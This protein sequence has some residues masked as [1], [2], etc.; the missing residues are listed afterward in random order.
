[1]KAPATHRFVL[2]DLGLPSRLTIG[3]FLV[4]IGFGYCA[5]L[6]QLHFQHATPGKL[7]PDSED[8][9]NTYYGRM[10]MSQLERLLVVDEAKPFN[11]SGSMRQ[12]FTTKSAGWKGAINR[13]SKEK[14]ISL[15]AAE[16]ELRSERDG[17]RLAILDW[18]RAG[19]DR[20]AF[21]DNN[22]LVSAHLARRPVTPDFI[23]DSPDAAPRVK[24]GSIIEN[25]CARCHAEGK[26]GSAS[27][28]PLET[29]QQLHDYC[30]VETTDAGMSLKKLAQ[31]THVHLIG[32]ALVYGLTGLTVTFTSYP[33]WLRGLI[34]PLPLIAQIVDIG[35]WWLGRADPTYA[36]AIVFTGGIVALSLALQIGLSLFNMFGKA[37]KAT[38]VVLVVATCLGAFLL[39]ERL[40][41]P[42]LSKERLSA[43]VS[44]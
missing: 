13:R 8:A 28:F 9:A 40:V 4:S 21:E 23:A 18:I 1:M 17:E 27:Q 3:A 33:A 12:T 5:A 14:Q 38:L 32:F 10:G 42:Y 41:E 16:E 6:V 43:T 11:G 44:E 35:F 19:A 26:S 34:G 39:K 30:E 37:G 29:W 24:I 25:R 22:F 20:K 15:R 31:T 36:R 2:R 7:L